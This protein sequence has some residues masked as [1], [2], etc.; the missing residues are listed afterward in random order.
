MAK[1]FSKKNISPSIICYLGVRSIKIME[2]GMLKADEARSGESDLSFAVEVEVESSALSRPLH[3]SEGGK[4]SRSKNK[5]SD[6]NL[7]CWTDLDGSLRRTGF[8]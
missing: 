8:N 6:C 1:K 5:F 7:R 3:A 2:C 4:A